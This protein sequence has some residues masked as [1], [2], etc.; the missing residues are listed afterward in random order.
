MLHPRNMPMCISVTLYKISLWSTSF[1][2]LSSMINDA[3][4]EAGLKE[5]FSV[6]FK[7]KVTQ[8]LYHTIIAVA[9]PIYRQNL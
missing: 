2:M 6:C 5:H 1:Y 9:L 3:V 7:T 8:P 4:T